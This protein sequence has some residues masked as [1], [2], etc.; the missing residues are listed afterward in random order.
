MKLSRKTLIVALVGVAAVAVIAFAVASRTKPAMYETEPITRGSVIEEV[1][2]TGSLSPSSKIALEPEVSGRIVKL[3]VDEGA[4]VKTGDVMAEIDSR[5]LSS[6]IASQRASLDSAKARL[7]ELVA[8]TTPEELALAE[9]AIVT[10]TT[11]RDQAIA[12]KGDA[13]TALA[14]AKANYDNVVAKADTL[15]GAKV[16]DL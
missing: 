14:N 1:T 5:D 11:K 10:A 16:D 13:E 6:R 15:M 7:A 3:R 8:G 9:A 2:V 4:V 12:A